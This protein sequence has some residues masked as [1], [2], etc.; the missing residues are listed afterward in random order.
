M[1][2]GNATDDVQRDERYGD[3]RKV[4]TGKLLIIGLAI[5]IIAGLTYTFVQYSRVTEPDVSA[6][7]AGWDRAE[8][9]REDD[10]FIFT[11]DVTRSDPSQEAYCIIFAMAYDYGEV[12]RRDV[13]IPPS[14]E[15]TVRV[16]VPIHTRDVAVAGDVYGCSTDIPPMLSDAAA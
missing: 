12:G 2:E 5:A 4:P 11:L 7:A 9:E 14:E 10:V 8:G 13:V 6:S 1:S 3:T 16:D 15:L